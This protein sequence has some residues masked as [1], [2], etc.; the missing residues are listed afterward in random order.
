M[1][2]GSLDYLPLEKVEGREHDEQVDTGALGVLLYEFLVGVPW[3][4]MESQGAMYR[5]IQ[6][7]NIRWSSGMLEDAKDLIS[8]LLKK[9]PRQ[10]QVM[11]CHQRQTRHIRT[12]EASGGDGGRQETKVEEE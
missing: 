7:V 6:K 9:D 1:L 5:T 2:C 3:F 4:E 12:R 11:S 8:K 10:R